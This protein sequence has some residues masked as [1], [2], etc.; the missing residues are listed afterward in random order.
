[1]MIC[2]HIIVFGERA[3]IKKT[4]QWR[5]GERE[6]KIYK[7]I[8]IIVNQNVMLAIFVNFFEKLVIL[9]IT[10]QLGRNFMKKQLIPVDNVDNSANN[11]FI[12]F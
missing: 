7:M 12:G 4:R 11:C 9:G 1:M 5:N 3:E 8:Y 6:N 2:G 10:I